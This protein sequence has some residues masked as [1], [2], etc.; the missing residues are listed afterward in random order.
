MGVDVGDFGG[1]E[2]RRRRRGWEFV[3]QVTFGGG[4]FFFLPFLAGGIWVTLF[5][6]L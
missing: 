2:A 3:R 6:R 4:F 5:L 1:V